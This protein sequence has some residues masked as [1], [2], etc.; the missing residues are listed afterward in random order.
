MLKTFF[1]KPRFSSSSSSSSS[2]QGRTAA[3]R[4]ISAAQLTVEKVVG[5]ER[6]DRRPAKEDLV[7][8]TTLSDHMLQVTWDDEHGWGTLSSFRRLDDAI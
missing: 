7:F 1:T 6:F 2:W 4:W 5:T 3:R 8:G